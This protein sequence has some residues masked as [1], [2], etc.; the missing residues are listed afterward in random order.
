MFFTAG[1]AGRLTGKVPTRWLIGPGFALVGAGLLLMHGI[2]P[3]D[4]WTHLLPGLILAGIGAGT[5]NVPLAST[6]VGVV[7]AGT[8]RDGVGHQLHATPG[9]HRHR[10]RRVRQHPGQPGVQLDRLAAE[11]R[12]ADEPL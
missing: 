9:R 7:R 5:V 4:D 3:G 12:P 11:R 2:S 1:I 10:R 8:G 6:A